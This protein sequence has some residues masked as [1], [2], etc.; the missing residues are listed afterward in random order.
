MYEPSYEQA[1]SRFIHL[2]KRRQ[3]LTLESSASLVE[4]L[5]NLHN[6]VVRLAEQ[7]TL[8]RILPRRRDLDPVVFEQQEKEW[9]DRLTAE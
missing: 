7:G 5:E 4:C 3:P 6:G 2:Q 1:M 8:H 9:P